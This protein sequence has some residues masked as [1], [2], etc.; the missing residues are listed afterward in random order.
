MIS[1]IWPCNNPTSIQQCHRTYAM[2]KMGNRTPLWWYSLE[3]G[4]VDTQE[5]HTEY[6]DRLLE[7]QLNCKQITI[8]RKQYDL[9]PWV[10]GNLM[11]CLFCANYLHITCKLL[12]H[13]LH[14]TCTQS[15]V[16]RLVY[17]QWLSLLPA[18]LYKGRIRVNIINILE[19]SQVL[20]LSLPCSWFL[21]RYS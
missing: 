3:C 11:I 7:P 19:K 4:Q 18:F 16:N 5:Y 1:C 2:S 15:H 21:S 20:Q 6:H 13:Y 9:L 10:P 17:Q 14:I 8:E 12:A